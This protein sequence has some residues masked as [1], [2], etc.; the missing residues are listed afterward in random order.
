V[1][2]SKAAR[3][4]VEDMGDETGLASTIFVLFRMSR[5]KRCRDN[6]TPPE[7]PTT[8]IP[9]NRLRVPRSLIPKS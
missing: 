6:K 1:T 4:V 9:K 5:I 3:L 2:P 8:S 7:R